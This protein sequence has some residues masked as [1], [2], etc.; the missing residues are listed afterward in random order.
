MNNFSLRKLTANGGHWG[1]F[2]ADWTAQCARHGEDFDQYATSSIP[3][4]ADLAAAPTDTAAVFALMDED[5]VHHGVFQA[6]A[7]YL[8]QTVGRTMRIRH[9]ILS[10]DYDFGR[11]AVFSYAETL[12]A[13]LGHSLSICRS[14]IPCKHLKFHL[15]SPADQQFF[16][17]LSRELSGIGHFETVKMVG[18]WLYLTMSE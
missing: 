10:P 1:N 17:S 15:R 16:N 14:T 2:I 13:I 18:A 8:P 6:N 12:S 3:V 7:A 4:L 9:L 5:G 11:Y